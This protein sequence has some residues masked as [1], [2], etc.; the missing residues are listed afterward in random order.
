MHKEGK[1]ISRY[2]RVSPRKARL[3]TQ[4]IYGKSAA[5]AQNQLAFLKSKAARL[6][7]KTLDSAIANAETNHEAV[8]ENL[9]V[10]DA[11]VD[12]GPRWKRAKSK[13]RGGRA[14][15]LKRTSH[16]TIVVGE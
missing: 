14:P 12:V 1:A 8:R 10:I 7:I 15:I 5:E 11:R 16:L 4:L 6:L 9:K 3:V 2:I 13:S